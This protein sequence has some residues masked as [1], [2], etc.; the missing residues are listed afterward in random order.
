MSESHPPLTGVDSDEPSSDVLRMERLFEA[1]VAD[2]QS[3]IERLIEQDGGLAYWKNLLGDLH[4]LGQQTRA[5]AGA[6]VAEPLPSGAE[7]IFGRYRLQE[8]LGR[9]GMGVVYRAWQADL[10]RSVAIKMILGGQ[11]STDEQVRRFHA[12]AQLAAQVRHPQIVTIHEVGEIDGQHFYAM[13]YVDGIGLDRYLAENRVEAEEAV[14]LLI[15]VIRAVQHLHERNIIH[16]DLKP[17]NLILDRE[18]RLHVAD[19][20]LATLLNPDT[21][22]TLSGTVLGTPAYMSPEQA[23]GKVRELSPAADVYSL[24]AIL[25]QM[26]AGRKV[27]DDDSPALL[28]LQVIEREPQPVMAFN[29]R[30]PRRLWW[31]VRR[32]LEKDPHRR[33]PNAG[34]LADDLERFLRD[35]SVVAG[36]DAWSQEIVRFARRHRTVMYRL[37][38]IGTALLVVLARMVQ[39]PEYASFYRPVIVDI[40]AWGLLVVLWDVLGQ[41]RPAQRDRTS[42]ATTLTDVVVLTHILWLTQAVDGPVVSLYHIVIS[43]AGL[44]LRPRR[45][46]LAVGASLIAYGLLMLQPPEEGMIRLPHLSILYALSLIVCGAISSSHA[47]R[48]ALL[49]IADKTP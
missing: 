31:I 17:A 24:G 11:L 5:G 1:V 13:E 23:A 9:G 39:T 26:L 49:T 16:R 32:C 37:A 45:V 44:S 18:R 43:A 35:D 6:D 33:Y 40:V 7:R 29:P 14:R 48:L 30:V 2:D 3:T 15:P 21:R 47:R 38:A 27:F 8:E 41:R 10:S 28:L 4:S 25:Y 42:T 22:Q 20:G 19:F 46:W 12:E 36:K 34:E